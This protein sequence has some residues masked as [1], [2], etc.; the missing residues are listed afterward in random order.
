MFF[1]KNQYCNQSKTLRTNYINASLPN[2][3]HSSRIY[4]YNFFIPTWRNVNPLIRKI[5]TSSSTLLCCIQKAIGINRWRKNDFK[6]Y[7]GSSWWSISDD[8]AEYLLSN[9]KW[10]ETQFGKR[11]FAAD[12]FAPQTV[13]MKSPFK[14]SI[15]ESNENI[16]GSLRLIDWQRGNGYGSPHIWKM[17][18]KQEI[19]NS[20]NLIG[21][22]FD[23]NMDKDIVDFV[24]NKIKE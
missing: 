23:E 8:F 24:L 12:E 5:A 10:I 16:D 11:T 22:K 13:I 2:K 18:D 15:Y 19:M 1:E 14:D 21:R 6:L 3:K 4:Y 17:D 20:G 7:H 9:S